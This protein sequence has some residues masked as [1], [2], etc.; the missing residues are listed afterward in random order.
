M[1]IK[2]RRTPTRISI[3]LIDTSATI[4]AS[5]HLTIVLIAFT[6]SPF[7]ARYTMTTI[8]GIIFSHHIRFTIIAD[9]NIFWNIIPQP[10]VPVMCGGILTGSEESL[11]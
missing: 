6:I 10:E 8:T 3:D 4:L 7:K 9:M 1:S 5:M 2:A 11:V